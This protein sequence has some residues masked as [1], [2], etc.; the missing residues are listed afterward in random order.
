MLHPEAVNSDASSVG[1]Y[2]MALIACVAAPAETLI[3]PEVI[4]F[5]HSLTTDV[6][7]GH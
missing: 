5:W 1:V 6:Q 4:L 3:K 2:C 7:A